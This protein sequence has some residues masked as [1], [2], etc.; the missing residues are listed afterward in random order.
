MLALRGGAGSTSRARRS[1]ASNG[2]HG[3]P[4]SGGTRSDHM[5]SR[6]VSM[7]LDVPQAVAY[8][9]PTPTRPQRRR[10]DADPSAPNSGASRRAAGRAILRQC[11]VATRRHSA[12]H[13]Y[14][15]SL[16]AGAREGSVASAA[17]RQCRSHVGMPR[18]R[19][20]GRY[21]FGLDGDKAQTACPAPEPAR[22]ESRAAI[23][24][25]HIFGLGETCLRARQC[26]RCDQPR[27]M[28]GNPGRL[29]IVPTGPAA[30]PS[31]R[32]RR[33]M[34]ARRPAACRL[35]GCRDLLRKVRP[36][37]DHLRVR[38]CCGRSI[39][40]RAERRMAVWASAELR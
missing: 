24:V 28:A 40:V 3:W 39:I 38:G 18:P 26:E 23:P 9:L 8:I 13:E 21:G 19:G 25:L 37:R 10:G 20:F 34:A 29:W 14:R 5:G 6:L 15:S 16:R 31:R 17:A 4:E 11:R 33:A 22:R 1:S 36:Q 12:D 32:S 27:R 30:R 35:P 7:L 2:V